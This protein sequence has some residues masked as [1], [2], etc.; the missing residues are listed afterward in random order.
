MADEPKAESRTV[1]SV[2]GK[3]KFHVWFSQV[4]QTFFEVEA[5]NEMDAQLKATMMWRD[6]NHTPHMCDMEE[7][8]NP[9]V[10]PR[11]TGKGEMQ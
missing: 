7:I 5:D 9:T 6:E 3:R 4:N 1:D 8:S 11:P 10:D 2:V